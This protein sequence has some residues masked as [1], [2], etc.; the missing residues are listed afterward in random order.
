MDTEKPRFAWEL[1]GGLASVKLVAHVLTIGAWGSEWFVDELYFMSCAEHLDWG[2]VDMP[3]LFPFLLGAVTAVLGD[4]LIVVRSIAA[5]AGAGLV[6]LVAALAREM[7]G[8]RWAQV[9]AALCVVLAPIYL[10]MHDITTMNALDPLFWAGCALVLARILN[11]GEPRLWLLFGLLAGLGVNSKHTFALWGLSLVIGLLMTGARRELRSKWIWLGGGVALLLFLP[12]LLWVADHGFPHLEQ[13]ANIRAVGRDVALSAPGFLAQQVL[14]LNA[15]AVVLW[16]G[17]LIWFFVDRGGRRYRP[18][19]IAWLSVIVVL[20]AI[21]GRPYYPAPAHPVVLA[22]GG[23]A[24][25]RFVKGGGWRRWVRPV[26]LTVAT[27]FGLVIAPMWLWC[28]PVDVYTRYTRFLGME[29]SRI[30]NHELGP[31]PQLFA[32]RYGWRQIAEEV[33]RIYHA[34]PE[35]D[36]AVASIFGS[37]YGTAGA[38]DRYRGEYELPRAISGH[39]S[40]FLWGPGGA[41]GEIMIILG[42]GRA[43]LEEIFESVEVVGRVHHPYSMPYNHADIHLCRG[44][45][46]PMDELWPRTKNYS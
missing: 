28:L 46:V 23:V 37:G 35:E 31:L 32:D 19:G 39:L 11:G 7:G 15:P 29:Q 16:L 44:L 9:T 20:I 3:P 33:A 6:L 43:G 38:V 25:S 42:E 36:R 34:L 4:S 21:G 45:R 17:G 14:M 8:D 26:V 40:Y 13:L 12:N 18:L 5:L 24:L 1:V 41:T 2:Y 22:A 30:E 27:V 10:I